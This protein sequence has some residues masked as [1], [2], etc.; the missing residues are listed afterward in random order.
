MPCLSQ[1][2]SSSLSCCE[3]IHAQ[4]LN[5]WVRPCVNKASLTKIDGEP[6]LA[7]GYSLPTPAFYLSA[8]EQVSATVKFRLLV[9]GR[10]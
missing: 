3:S 2:L 6:D 7:N 10:K 5:K 8:A 1:A 4:Y 9:L